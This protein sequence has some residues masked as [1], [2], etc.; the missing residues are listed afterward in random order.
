MTLTTLII[1]GWGHGMYY[2][3]WVG[4]SL[5][6]TLRSLLTLNIFNGRAVRRQKYFEQ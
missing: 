1:K 6:E 2:K 4:F 5:F 3:V